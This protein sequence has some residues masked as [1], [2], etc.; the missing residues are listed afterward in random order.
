MF[1]IAAING[2][3]M[4]GQHP[5]IPI[6]PHQQAHESTRAI[7]AGAHAVHVHPRDAE[8]KESLLAHDIAASLE[9]IRGAN[10][11][12]PVGVSTG[13][14]ILPDITKR[15]ALIRAWDVLPDF[16]SVNFHEPGALQMAKLLLSKG[17]GIEAGVWNVEAARTFQATGLARECLRVLL[18]PGQQPGKPEARLAE[19]EAVLPD[20][21]C[22]GLLHGFETST[23]D[24]VAL[25][26]RRGYDTRIGFEDTVALP[27]G[28]F[29]RDNGELVATAL[30]II[31]RHQPGEG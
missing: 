29:A 4:P 20:L 24:L 23:W 22:P 27:D 1:L 30:R 14:W 6:K 18:E 21:P 10:P 3:R 17:I 31:S 5:A 28:N 12:T 25:A 13:E 9:A 11:N 19:I 15:Q 8:G 16:A 2:R 7:S 26:A